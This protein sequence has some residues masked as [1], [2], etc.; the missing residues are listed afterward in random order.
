MADLQPTIA[1]TTEDRTTS[2]MVLLWLEGFQPVTPRRLPVGWHPLILSRSITQSIHW[3][4]LGLELLLEGLML[5]AP[6]SLDVMGAIGEYLV[7][8]HPS[9]S[10]T[11]TLKTAG[12]QV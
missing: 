12:F 8:R 9:T 5:L 11:Y 6:V 1:T 10:T 2:W 4:K 7:D 3:K